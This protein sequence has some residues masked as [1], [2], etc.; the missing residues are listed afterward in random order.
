MPCVCRPGHGSAGLIYM[1]EGPLPA[2]LPLNFKYI[3]CISL[4]SQIQYYTSILI[5]TVCIFY[6]HIGIL[7]EYTFGTVFPFAA[8]FT[9]ILPCF[10]HQVQNPPCHIL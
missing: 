4:K 3:I 2:I 7:S 10:F 1:L 6:M 5:N 8:Y 9:C